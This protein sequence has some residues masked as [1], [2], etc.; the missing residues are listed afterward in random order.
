MINCKR[1]KSEQIKRNGKV[2][3][4]QR[5]KC[6]ECHLNFVE[7]DKRVKTDLPIKKALAVILYSIGKASFRMLGKLFN[8]SHSL[9]YRWISKEAEMLP[10]P[11]I[12]ADIREIEFDEMWHFIGSKK[13][14]SG[15]SKPWIVATGKLLPGLSAVVMLQRLGSSTLK[16]ST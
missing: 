14:K 10:E 13:T 2:R 8:C 12:D 4:K 5:Y 6:K 16:S 9:I 15:L 7:G 3:D 1:C 11:S